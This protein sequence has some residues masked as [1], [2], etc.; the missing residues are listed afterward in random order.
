[1]EYIT[2]DVIVFILLFAPVFLTAVLG[3]VIFFF[4]KTVDK[5]HAS[6]KEL[7]SFKAQKEEIISEAQK[8]YEEIVKRASKKAD[9][10]IS[11]S[12]SLNEKIKQS[13]EESYEKAL[14]KELGKLNEKNIDILNN[15]SKDIVSMLKQKAEEDY[16][17]VKKE[18]EEYKGERLK[19][20]DENIYNLLLDVS[21]ETIGKALT[22]EDHQELILEALD[23]AK[24]EKGL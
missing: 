9:E 8:E 11:S 5:L 16:S 4:A 23:K 15:I 6:Q 7:L 20:I 19:K 2:P 13:A 14:Q 1:M 21:K 10:I 17:K 24:K 18:L 12:F 3:V 22:F